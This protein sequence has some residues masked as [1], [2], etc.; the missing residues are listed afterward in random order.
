[1][2][3]ISLYGITVISGWLALILNDLNQLGEGWHLLVAR[4]FG[5]AIS[6]GLVSTILLRYFV[7]SPDK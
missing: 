4:Y 5:V 2:K 6:C 1:M 7:P 3:T